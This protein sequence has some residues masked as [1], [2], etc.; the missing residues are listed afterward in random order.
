MLFPEPSG[1]SALA[2]GV[3]DTIFYNQDGSMTY[4]Y[5]DGKRGLLKTKAKNYI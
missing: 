2:I 3:M 4:V 1:L 5:T